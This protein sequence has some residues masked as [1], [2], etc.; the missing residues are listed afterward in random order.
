VRRGRRPVERRDVIEE[1]AVVRVER[2]DT[3]PACR[4]LGQPTLVRSMIAGR[5]LSPARRHS[6]VTRSVALEPSVWAS[7]GVIIGTAY[8]WSYRHSL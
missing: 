4:L 7:R 6:S 2:L 1:R 3:Q 5:F 8:K